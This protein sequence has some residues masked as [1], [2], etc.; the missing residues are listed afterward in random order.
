MIPLTGGTLNGWMVVAGR[1][2]RG[3]GCHCLARTEF[4]FYKMQRGVPVVAHR[5][6]NP[7]WNHEVAGSILGLAQRVKDPALP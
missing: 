1:W 5:L 4:Q 7:T 6:T 2:G 3:R